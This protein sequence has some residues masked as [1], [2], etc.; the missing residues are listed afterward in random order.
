MGATDEKAGGH[1]P[2]R[3]RQYCRIVD[4]TSLGLILIAVLAGGLYGIWVLGS[5]NLGFVAF[6]VA[7]VVVI[8][9]AAFLLKVCI[10]RAM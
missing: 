10:R 3:T 7:I 6:I 8:G 2:D 1:S 9:G 5:V 4:W